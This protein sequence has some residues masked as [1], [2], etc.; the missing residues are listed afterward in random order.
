MAQP[1]PAATPQT[2]P[3]SWTDWADLVLASPVILSA[4]VDDVDRLGRKQAPDVPPGQVRALVTARLTAA[5]KSPSV[6]PAAAAWLWQGEAD[7]RGRAPFSKALPVLVF[8]SPM[9]G[10]GDPSVQPL[11]LTAAHAQQPWSGA[12]EAT[13]R[14]ILAEA[15]K[16]AAQGL[17]VTAVKDGFHSEGDVPGRSESQF[18][19]STEGGR[20]LTLVV[21]RTAGT[22]PTVRVATGDLVDRAA[23]VQ[24]QTL[25][26]RGLACGM[27]RAL[28]ASLAANPALSADY[29]AARTS[30]GVCGR[31]VPQG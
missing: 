4:T 28:P 15:L 9:T 16:P 3:L 6:L 11:R 19:L 7:A 8:G 22:E 17:M 31:T 29:A 13:V 10:G 25:L 18:F 12:S 26:W 27:P 20:P 30:I 21:S 14:S 2:A 1:K 23:P 5:L 24:R